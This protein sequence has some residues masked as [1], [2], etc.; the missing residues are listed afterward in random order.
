[1]A[2][3]QG[4]AQNQNQKKEDPQKSK[5]TVNVDFG[6]MFGKKKENSEQDAKK[7]S[8]LTKEL[9]NVSTRLKI[10]E[11][12]YINI[13]KKMQVIEQDML[14]DN[15]KTN[16]EIHANVEGIKEINGT[17]EELKSKLRIIVKELKLCAKSDD[18]QMLQKYISY[19]EPVDFIT[20]H[21]MERVIEEEITEK[22]EM[23][24]EEILSKINKNQN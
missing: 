4:N 11:E 17:I 21:E 22:F 12:R 15:K 13:R 23:L 20:R 16:K 9:N 24:K 1:M 8:E 10:I 3:G 18:V 19:W 6:S 5:G 14:N 7:V 2:E